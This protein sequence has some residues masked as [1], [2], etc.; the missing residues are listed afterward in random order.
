MSEEIIK[1]PLEKGLSAKQQEAIDLHY[2]IKKDGD[3]AASALVEFS[4]GLKRMRDEKLYL[5]L[6]FDKFEDY[7]EQAVGIGQ[8][9][10]YTYIQAYEKLGSS[11]LQSTAKI[12]ITK[13][14]LL[15]MIPP[16]E[17]DE[18][19]D[20]HDVEEMSTREMKEVVDKL[21]AAE[22]QLS[23]MT[24]ERDKLSGELSEIKVSQTQQTDEKE[25]E[26]EALKNEL[27]ELHSRPVEVAVQEADPEAVKKQIDEA[28]SKEREKADKKL[29]K[30]EDQKQ[31]DIDAA[32]E[33][34]KKEAA[35][36]AKEEIQASLS[37][38]E[39]EKNAALERA[40]ELEKKLKLSA[41]P[42]TLRFSFYFEA[43]Q[44]NFNRLSGCLAK[45]KNSGD[46]E[47]EAKLTGALKKIIDTMVEKFN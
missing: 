6:G 18:F 2:E 39:T 15:T 10:A 20:K 44:E 9:Q 38:E 43:F 8:S 32:V 37:A 21:T 41:N 7:V 25:K 36:K 5:E 19:L 26:I 45:I 14:K 1:I 24:T 27:K 35:E 4:K 30:A 12:G 22:E 46:T 11:V 13:L 47:T 17:R 23:F 42:E 33:A 29:K 16:T 28:I 31:Q 34:V 40:A 3:L